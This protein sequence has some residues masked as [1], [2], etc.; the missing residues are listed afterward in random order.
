MNILIRERER[1]EEVE[2]EA[3]VTDTRYGTA[4]TV[5]SLTGESPSIAGS[6]PVHQ[7]EP[8]PAYES[9]VLVHKN[10][11]SSVSNLNQNY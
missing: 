4:N 10:H 7:S 5:F 9:L 11:V 1:A 6:G 8:P 2:V 3:V